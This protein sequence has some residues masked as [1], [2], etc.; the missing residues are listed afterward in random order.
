MEEKFDG[1]VV[2]A[3]AELGAAYKLPKNDLSV[4]LKDRAGE[5]LSQSM[6]RL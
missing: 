4:V 3:A 1:M 2:G 6:W 5:L